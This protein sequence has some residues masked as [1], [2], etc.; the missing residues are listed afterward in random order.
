[1]ILVYRIFL[2]LWILGIFYVSLMPNPAQALLLSDQANLS[3]LHSLAFFVLFL[4]F[5][6]S[7]TNSSKNLRWKTLLI[8]LVL[9]MTVSIS[10]E[11]C[12]LFAPPRTFSFKDIL[13][14]GTTALVA[15]TIIVAV[16][17]ILGN[18]LKCPYENP[19]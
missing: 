16:K 13:V 18:V 1:M 3:I 15:L 2:I 5:Y 6:F 11:F 14:D 19:N 8:C 9:T 12:Q 10:K 4:L 7:L 17:K